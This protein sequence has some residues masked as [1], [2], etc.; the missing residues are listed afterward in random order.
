MGPEALRAERG[1]D[2]FWEWSDREEGF[3]E[4]LGRVFESFLC[5]FEPKSKQRKAAKALRHECRMAFADAVNFDLSR[6]ALRKVPNVRELRLPNG[7][8]ARPSRHFAALFSETWV[9]SSFEIIR[10]NALVCCH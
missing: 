8:G 7:T 6:S 4:T 1:L 10:K 3:E 9:S 5:W 2:G